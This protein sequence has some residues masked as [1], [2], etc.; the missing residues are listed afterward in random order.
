MPVTYDRP[1]GVYSDEESTV[2]AGYGGPAPTS[3]DPGQ[4]SIEDA[5]AGAQRLSSGNSG[6]QAAISEAIL[7]EQLA[8][9]SKIA[10]QNAEYPDKPGGRCKAESS[11]D[12]ETTKDEN[13]VD[14]EE[15]M[16][17]L[18][19]RLLRPRPPLKQFYDGAYLAT[20][21]GGDPLRE[22]AMV[23]AGAVIMIPCVGYRFSGIF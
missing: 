10:L 5:K 19:T 20:T 13:A 3:L 1:G 6:G 11:G 7:A 8:V 22:C 9:G 12:G 15:S 2:N 21:D 4:A 14:Q 23:V 18:P 16:S 17:R